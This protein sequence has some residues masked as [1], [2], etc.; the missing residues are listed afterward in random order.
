MASSSTNARATIPVATSV[1]WQF[2]FPKG[3]QDLPLEASSKIEAARLGGENVAIYDSGW[4]KKKDLWQPYK[5]DFGTMQQTN[6]SSGRV[7]EARRIADEGDYQ[8]D[9]DLTELEMQFIAAV[10]EEI[11]KDHSTLLQIEDL[12]R[13]T[14]VC[15]TAVWLGQEPG[16]E[17]RATSPKKKIR[18]L[19]V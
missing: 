6:V 17:E 3:W 2:K 15:Q 8:V 11:N 16:S 4:S 7:R 9:C 5:I 12:P 10:G 13:E 1:K 19:H 14:A 18:Q